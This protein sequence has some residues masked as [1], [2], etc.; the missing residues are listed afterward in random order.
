[1]AAAR[2]VYTTMNRK[3]VLMRPGRNVWGGCLRV[4][5]GSELSA[6]KKIERAMGPWILMSSA[7]WGDAATNQKLAKMMGY[8]FGRRRAEQAVAASFGH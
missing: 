4:V 3:M 2:W 6:G 1:M 8:I 5:L 7:E